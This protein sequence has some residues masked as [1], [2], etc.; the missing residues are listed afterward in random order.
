MLKKRR[1]FDA[2]RNCFR[3]PPN[4]SKFIPNFLINKSSVAL[5]QNEIDLLNNGLNFALPHKLP[6]SKE[7][8]VDAEVAASRLEEEISEGV[9]NDIHRVFS[10]AQHVTGK[11]NMKMCDAVKSLNSKDIYITKADKGNCVVVLNK[12]DYDDGMK[13]LIDDGNYTRVKNPL[14]RMYI[15]HRRKGRH[16]EIQ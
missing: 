3:R 8:I 11:F 14:N 1:K 6:P 10:D 5:D 4:K 7:Q 16:K 2:L 12:C 13:K 15:V 9:R